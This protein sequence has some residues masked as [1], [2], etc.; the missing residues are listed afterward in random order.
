MAGRICDDLNDNIIQILKGIGRTAHLRLTVLTLESMKNPAVLY[1]VF[2]V[3]MNVETCGLG[4]REEEVV[5]TTLCDF[6]GQIRR[7][8]RGRM[9]VDEIVELYLAPIHEQV[10][11]LLDFGLD[12]VVQLYATQSASRGGARPRFYCPNNRFFKCFRNNVTLLTRGAG[13]LPQQLPVA[14][15]M[16]DLPAPVAEVVEVAEEAP[17]AAVVQPVEEDGFSIHDLRERLSRIFDEHFTCSIHLDNFHNVILKLFFG[18]MLYAFNNK[19]IFFRLL[20]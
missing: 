15:P 17:Q 12:R 11:A 4:S 5:Y 7:M 9:Y 2:E 18:F 19:F 1:A 3:L 13:E 16:V 20:T 14:Q 8:V 10:F 6:I